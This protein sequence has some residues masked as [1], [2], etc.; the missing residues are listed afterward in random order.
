MQ[1]QHEMGRMNSKQYAYSIR[2]G[3]A[4]ETHRCNVVDQRVP[5]HLT[6]I[7]RYVMIGAVMGGGSK[8]GVDPHN[9]TI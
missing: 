2:S 9:N 3:S 4:S 1:V 6:F 5:S 7:T 8:G